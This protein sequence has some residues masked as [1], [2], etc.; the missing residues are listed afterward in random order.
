MSASRGQTSPSPERR[1][2]EFLGRELPG[3]VLYNGDGGAAAAWLGG[4]GLELPNAHWQMELPAALVVA[5]DDLLTSF[6][7]TRRGWQNGDLRPQ[8]SGV[9]TGLP[10]G[11]CVVQWDGAEHFSPYRLS[12]L[13]R[14]GE[15]VG[16]RFPLGAHADYC[17]SPRHFAAFWESS[18]LPA[19]LLPRGPTITATSQF[20]AALTR[21]RQRLQGSSYVRPVA[22]FSFVGGRMAQ[23]AYHDALLDCAHLMAAWRRSGVLPVLR[24]AVWDVGPEPDDSDHQAGLERAAKGLAEMWRQGKPGGPGNKHAGD[25]GT[26]GRRS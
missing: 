23:R 25:C 21:V 9:I 18:K 10:L 5:L 11:P 4:L 6:G 22:G 20:A 3:Q 15:L 26:R 19:T 24:V 2:F 1:F 14:L 7:G 13:R 17:T 12:A 8:L 16:P